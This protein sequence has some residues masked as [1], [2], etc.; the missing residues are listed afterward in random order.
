MGEEISGFSY[1]DN[2]TKQGMKEVFV[3]YNYEIDPHGAVGYLALKDYQAKNPNTKGV[4]LETA[5]PSKFLPDVES[6][7]NKTINVPH[8]LAVL[9][10]K[11]KESIPIGITFDPFKEFLLSNY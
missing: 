8:R 3:Q 7:L 10:N 6:T 11:K 4:I 2:Q 1:N 5:H 9:A